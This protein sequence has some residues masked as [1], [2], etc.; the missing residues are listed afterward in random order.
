MLLREGERGRRTPPKP[1]TPLTSTPRRRQRGRGRDARRRIG[2]GSLG[3]VK[4]G[5]RG[6]RRGESAD[7]GGVLAQRARKTGGGAGQQVPGLVQWRRDLAPAG[8]EGQQH[9]GGRVRLDQ[10]QPRRARPGQPGP[11][12]VG[13]RQDRRPQP[14]GGHA[15][16]GPGCPDQRLARAPAHQHVDPATGEHP[17]VAAADRGRHGRGAHPA[18]DPRHP[19]RADHRD[20]APARRSR[21]RRGRCRVVSSSRTRVDRRR[22]AQERSESGELSTTGAVVLPKGNMPRHAPPAGAPR[23]FR[24]RFQRRPQPTNTAQFPMGRRWGGQPGGCRR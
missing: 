1:P 13:H 24:W 15:R 9:D 17:A 22:R 23:R 11:G 2:A 8:D 5:R 4:A 21:R 10:P 14:V 6:D 20:T 16:R 12:V 18:T 3:A 19:R 7:R